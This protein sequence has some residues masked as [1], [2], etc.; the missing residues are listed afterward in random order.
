MLTLEFQDEHFV[1][2]RKVLIIFTFG[3]SSLPV[4]F[5]E[6][7]NSARVLEGCKPITYNFPPREVTLIL[8]GG[9]FQQTQGLYLVET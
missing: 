5:P 8:Q 7:F 1:E 3:D 9:Q 2:N 4:D 6:E